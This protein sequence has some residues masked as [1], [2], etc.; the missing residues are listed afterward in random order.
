MVTK[1]QT[2]LK[3]TTFCL[4][5]AIAPPSG[6]R[7]FRINNPHRQSVLQQIAISAIRHYQKYAKHLPIAPCRFHPTCSNY[8]IQSIENY[9]FFVG[10]LMTFDRLMRCNPFAVASVDTP[11]QH[12][13]F[14]HRPTI[15]RPA[16][17][18]QNDSII[19]IAKESPYRLPCSV[20]LLSSD[21][22]TD[23]MF[24]FAEKLFNENDYNRAITEYKR[25]IYFSRSKDIN[26][27]NLASY[28]IGLCHYY[29]GDYDSAM[30][31]FRNLIQSSELDEKLKPKILFNMGK[32]Y[33]DQNIF[34]LSR[35]K[36]K[37]IVENHGA[38]PLAPI[39]QLCIGL[40]FLKERDWHQA[41]EE[42]KKINSEFG[43]KLSNEVLSVKKLSRKSTTMAG[44]LS[45]IPGL[46]KIYARKTKD[47][48]LSFGFISLLGYLTYD[49]YN[50][51]LY[52]LSGFLGLAFLSYY[53]GNIYGSIDAVRAFNIGQEDMLIRKIESEV[54]RF[55]EE[56][57]PKA[58]K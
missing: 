2:Y 29:L 21:Y 50:R 51:Q 3:I 17:C 46:G 47:G 43:E 14:S 35:H 22:T 12:Y 25:Y 19:Q 11:E 27:I 16:I 1:T 6:A 23:E 58:I 18:I 9:G 45:I 31:T 53:L 28:R 10:Y 20:P 30:T 33:Y 26:S 34:Y 15:G 44:I 40:S 42:F 7:E 41:S 54:D 55:Y 4:I 48:I 38:H 49:T 39:A 8:A 24:Q 5:L 56:V 36:F 37:E 32:I 13:I 52:L 57:V